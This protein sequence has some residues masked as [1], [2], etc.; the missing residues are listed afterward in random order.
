M[1]NL[2][3]LG[4]Y[5]KRR[6][7]LVQLFVEQTSAANVVR[8]DVYGDSDHAGCLKTRKSTTG[9]VLMRDAHCLKVSSHTQSTISLSSGESEYYGIVKCA[10]IG[11][12]ARSM[13]AD[14]GVCADVVI[15]TDDSSSGLAVGSRRG[16]DR[17][18]Q[19]QTRY[20]WVQQRVQEGDLRLKTESGETNVRDALAKILDEKRMLNLL[21]MMRWTNIVGA[22]VAMTS[23]IVFSSMVFQ[24]EFFGASGVAQ[25]YFLERD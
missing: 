17:L 3:R 23:D 14:F 13:L 2:K 9:M 4:R 12:G 10:A 11:L 19:V 5:L 6:P 22:R 18:R 16:L 15:R 8:L 1:T 25:W 21:T 7:R 20:L 24:Q